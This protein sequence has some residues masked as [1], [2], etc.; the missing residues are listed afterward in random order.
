MQIVFFVC[1]VEDYRN[2]LKLSCTPIAFTSY[3][4]FL[5]NK[6]RSQ[7]SLPPSFSA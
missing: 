3:K 6:M 5:K 7:T 4:A 1:Q 2:T